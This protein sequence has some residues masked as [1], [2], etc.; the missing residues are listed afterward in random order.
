MRRP[1]T[2]ATMIRK[3]E[4]T[5]DDKSINCQGFTVTKK[6]VMEF[7]FTFSIPEKS[8]LFISSDKK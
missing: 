3:P 2:R 8:T 5:K 6:E 1:Q 7:S 4:S